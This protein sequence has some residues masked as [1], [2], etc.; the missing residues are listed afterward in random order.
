MIKFVETKVVFREI[1]D[2]ITLAI[3]LSGCTIKC[4]GCHSAHLQDDKG[5][6]LTPE[7]IKELINK[8]KGITCI[9]FMGGD[10]AKNYLHNIFKIVKEQYPDLKLGWYSGKQI[11]E[12]DIPDEAQHLDYIKV[13]PYIKEKGGLDNKN[14]NQKLYKINRHTKLGYI[15]KLEDITYKLWKND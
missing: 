8:N 11:S 3:N 4:P 14:T 10:H 9:A 13:G 1:P 6:P 5:K 15:K 7:A 2:E 12:K